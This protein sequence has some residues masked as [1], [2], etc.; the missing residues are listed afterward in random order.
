MLATSLFSVDSTEMAST[1]MEWAGYIWN[2]ID[3]F[4]YVILGVIL[5]V[6][7]ITKIISSFN[8]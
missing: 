7:V 8:R 2:T 3:L 1:T 4:V 6:F 5:S